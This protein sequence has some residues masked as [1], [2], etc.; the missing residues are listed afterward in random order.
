M[1][2]T[3]GTFD[4]AGQP[5][6]NETKVG[7]AVSKDNPALKTGLEKAMAE[8]VADGSYAKLLAHWN[9]PPSSAAY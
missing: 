2:S 1:Q 4:A 8:I 6:D 7:I 5:F 3:P 9:L